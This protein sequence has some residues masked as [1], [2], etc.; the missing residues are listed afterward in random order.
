MRGSSPRRHASRA[1][2]RGDVCDWSTTS[3]PCLASAV[4]GATLRFIGRLLGGRSGGIAKNATRSAGALRPSLCRIVACAS[5]RGVWCALGRSLLARASRRVRRPPHAGDHAGRGPGRRVARA[6]GRAAA[7]CHPR[8]TVHSVQR[9]VKRVLK[10]K[11]AF[12]NST[13]G[14]GARHASARPSPPR[15][16]GGARRLLQPAASRARPDGP[17]PRR[18]APASVAARTLPVLAGV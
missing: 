4:V 15:G 11:Q 7:Q 5:R 2:L 8:L 18:A 17:T 3:S 16:A 9:F 14:A 10:Q 12:D 13:P 6:P 1:S